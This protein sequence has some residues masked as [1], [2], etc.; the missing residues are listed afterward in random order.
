MSAASDWQR[1]TLS[2]CVTHLGRGQSPSYYDGES[3]YHAIGQKCVRNGTVE[4]AL[5]RAHQPR[6]KVKDEAELSAGDVCIN[7]TGTGTI[8]RVGLWDGSRAASGVHYFADS[9]L[10]VARPDLSEVH[11]KYLAALLASKPVQNEIERFCFSGSTN[12]VELNRAAFAAL[13]FA[14]PPGPEQCVV[15]DVL[16][17]IDAAFEQTEAIIAKQQRTKAG[18]MQDLLTRGIDEHWNIR[19]RATHE[20]KDSLFGRIPKE[21]ETE[22]FGEACE[23]VSVGIATATTK[24]FRD[25][26]VPLL[27]NQ[28]VLDGEFDLAKILYVSPEFDRINKSKRLR[29]GDLVTMRTGYPGR[30]AVVPPF[31]VG[32][33]TFTTLISTPKKR[34]VS[35]YLSTLINSELCKGQIARLQGGGAQQ[36]LNVGWIVGMQILRPSLEEQKRIV[37]VIESAEQ[38]ISVEMESAA[39][40]RALK[41]GLEEDLLVGRVRVTSLLDDSGR[42]D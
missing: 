6:V 39:K 13:E 25:Q 7:S 33:Q 11:P 2:K 9:H 41:A 12:Q 42:A 40:L 30:T 18:M 32:W 26:G 16:S 19:T 24:H 20:F 34:Y 3:D 4:P 14:I 36:N 22:R 5:S 17:Q 10:T 8:G 1:K 38:N 27:R 21:W 35:E 28:N 31:M 23:R 29:P 15:A 37:S